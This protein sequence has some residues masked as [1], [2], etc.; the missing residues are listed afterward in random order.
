MSPERY[1]ESPEPFVYALSLGPYTLN[2]FF[3]YDSEK[4]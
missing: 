3:N 1:I 2:R 4:R